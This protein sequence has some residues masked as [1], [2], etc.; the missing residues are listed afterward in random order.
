MKHRILHLLVAASFV[1]AAACSILD[2]KVESFITPDNFYLN[3]NQARA[4]LDGCYIP[5]RYIYTSTFELATE[6]VTDLCFSTSGAQDA[7]LDISPANPRFGKTM[8]TQCYKGVRYCNDA[9]YRLGLSPMDSVKTAPF[10]AEAKVLRGLYYYLLTSFFG[11]V[12]FYEEAVIDLDVLDRIQHLPRMSADDTRDFIVDDIA[13]CIGALPRGRSCDVADERAGSAMGYMVMAKAAMWNRRWEDAS[14]AL[15]SLESFYGAL[16]AYPLSDIPFRNKNTPESIFEIQHTYTRGG[17]SV[18]SNLAPMCMPQNHKSGTSIYSNVEI[19]E[20]GEEATVWEPIRP[21]RY[22]Y[23]GLMPDSAGDLRKGMTCVLGWNGE[24]FINSSGS[25]V[26]RP[27]LGPKF[28]CPGMVSTYDSN[29]YKVFRYADALLMQAE[30]LCMLDDRDGSLARLNQVKARAG[31]KQL[32][33]VSSTSRLMEEIQKERGR[34]LFGE[35]QRKFDLVR[36]GIWYQVVNDFSDYLSALRPYLQPCKE[37]YPI[38]DSECGLSGRA[39]DNNAY[40]AK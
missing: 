39:L 19:E 40:K 14:V 22:F 38:P 7:K 30:C 2:E 28:W 21:N 9:V 3:V 23:E 18:V 4:G 33:S 17:L 1:S 20:L 35:F 8:W 37:Y 10:I 15:D 36:W 13:S 25:K 32:T 27:Y 29:N 12:P 26:S 5:L 6:G 31:I 16:S 34:E 11:D 24:P